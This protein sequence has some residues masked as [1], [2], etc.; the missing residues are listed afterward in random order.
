[1]TGLPSQTPNPPRGPEHASIS[2]SRTP[3]WTTGPRPRVVSLLPSATEIVALLGAEAELVGRSHE[4]DWPNSVRGVPVLTSQTTGQTINQATASAASHGA[5]KPAIH[6]DPAA[7]ERQVREQ[8]AAG[9]PLYRV[10]E[11]LLRSLKP[12]IIITQDLCA[13]CSIDLAS[14][15]RIA[16]SMSPRPTIVSLNPTTIEGVIDDV[17]T[18]GRALGLESRAMSE[19]VKLRERFAAAAEFVNPYE[20]GPNVAFLEWTDPIFI[21]GHWT[22]QM[23]ERAGGRHV[24]NPSVPTENAGAAVGP[25]HAQRRAGK[26]IAVPVEILVASRPDALIVCPCGLDLAATRHAVGELAK[27]SWWRELPAVRN[28]RVALVDGNQYF[29]RP[30]P[31][32]AEAF[33]WMVGWLQGRPGLVGKGFGW[34]EWGG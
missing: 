13:V 15:Q 34:E 1:M 10:D 32:L 20:E 21:G 11:L 18:V 3:R 16:A 2:G 9:F 27:K 8:L 28:G 12:D 31:R 23:I 33:E 7:I 4:C 6:L 22:V 29:N 19:T 17:L 14:V 25:Q 5:D 30:G 24:L 26:S